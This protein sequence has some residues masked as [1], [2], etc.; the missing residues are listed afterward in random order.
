M[1]ELCFRRCKPT[2]QL[3]RPAGTRGRCESLTT[4]DHRP[5][6][7]RGR[8]RLKLA[9]FP[10]KLPELSNWKKGNRRSHE[11]ASKRLD[12]DRATSALDLAWTSRVPRIRGLTYGHSTLSR[13]NLTLHGVKGELGNSFARNDSPFFGKKT[14]NYISRKLPEVFFI[15][16]PPEL[17]WSGRN[18][19]QLITMAK[20]YLG[21]V[22]EIKCRFGRVFWKLVFLSWFAW[23][24]S[25]DEISSGITEG[26]KSQNLTGN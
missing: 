10:T 18:T 15:I 5:H 3:T 6:P 4:R 26:I 23:W 25:L 13:T 21:G 19:Y 22:Q 24:I 14:G 17:A 16:G 2:D 11:P 7:I 20:G 12:N 1:S 9:S 8:V